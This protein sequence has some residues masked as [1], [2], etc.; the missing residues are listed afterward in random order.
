MTPTYEPLPS[1]LKCG[2]KITCPKHYDTP[3]VLEVVLVRDTGHLLLRRT[4][5]NAVTKQYTT[6]EMAAFDYEL[7]TEGK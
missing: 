1:L 4:N 6:A 7:V 2:D 5:G 3:E